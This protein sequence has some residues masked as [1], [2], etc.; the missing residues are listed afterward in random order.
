MSKILVTYATKQ[1]S[2]HEVAEEIGTILTERG[3]E[4]EIVPV[5]LCAGP[6]GYDAVVFGAP[7]YMGKLLKPGARFLQKHRESLAARPLAIFA[8]G[9]RGLPETRDDAQKQLDR[10]IQRSRLT[11]VSVALF[12]GV[13]R[14][15]KLRF[16][17]NRMPAGDWRDWDA[18][19]AWGSELAPKLAITAPA[20]A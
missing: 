16:P 1:G 14:P 2:T 12:D 18:I 8:L 13:V 3:H 10:A 17:F 4:I 9:P 11:P 7:L 19:R 5:E 20:T 6:D 15:D